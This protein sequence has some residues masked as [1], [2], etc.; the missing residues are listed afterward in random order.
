MSYTSS[1]RTQLLHTDIKRKCCLETELFVYSYILG[2]FSSDRAYGPAGGQELKADRLPIANEDLASRLSYIG[3]KLSGGGLTESSS[4]SFVVSSDGNSGCSLDARSV[5][6]YFR[7]GKLSDPHKI[8]VFVKKECC[9]GAVMRSFFALS[10]SISSPEDRSCYLEFYFTD[11]ETAYSFQRLVENNGINASVT[12]RRKRYV[13]YVKKA[14]TICD[15]LTMM[16][17][18]GESI[19]FQMAKTERE[20]SNSVN[21]VMNCDMANIDRAREK[22]M[23]EAETIAFLEDRDAL[24]LL[25]EDLVRLAEIRLKNPDLSHGEI[26]RMMVPEISHSSVSLKMKR[27]IAFADSLR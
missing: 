1:I 23:K 20:V 26:G 15:A 4:G 13:C 11:P 3:T 19:R 22:G 27:I 6:S 16:A 21:R 25:P 5:R 10:G 18:P 14:E 7:S 8:D 2:A 12:K 17:L 9:A 24:K